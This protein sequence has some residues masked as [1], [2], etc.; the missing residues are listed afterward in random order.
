MDPIVHKRY[1]DYRDRYAYFGKKRAI[2]S[3]DAFAEADAEHRALF[4]KGDTRD[5]E[6]DARFVELS[7]LL[8]RD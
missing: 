7:R 8:F 1:L 2:L 5:D 6:D 3:M 4:A